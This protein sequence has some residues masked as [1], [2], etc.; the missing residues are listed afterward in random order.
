MH[1]HLVARI[2]LEYGDRKAP[3][4]TTF[5]HLFPYVHGVSSSDR[6]GKAGGCFA[7]HIEELAFAFMAMSTKANPP[8]RSPGAGFP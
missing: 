7:Q 5:S 4:S 1:T 8:I 3:I 2:L 6:V